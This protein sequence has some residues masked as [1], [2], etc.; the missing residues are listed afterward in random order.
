MVKNGLKWPKMGF[1]HIFSGNGMWELLPEG[2][3]QLQPVWRLRRG[4]PPGEPREDRE[5]RLLS[6]IGSLVNVNEHGL[7]R[8]D[9][10]VVL[11]RQ[12]CSKHQMAK[13]IKCFKEINLI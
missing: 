13:V 3:R 2:L 11:S 9:L 1:K 10:S 6:P 5:R 4:L 7:R 8:G 12:N